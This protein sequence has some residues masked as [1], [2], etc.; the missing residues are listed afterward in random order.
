LTQGLVSH[1]EDRALASIPALLP[2]STKERQAVLETLNRMIAARGAR[3][4]DAQRL[5]IESKRSSMS[6]KIGRCSAEGFRQERMIAR[7]TSSLLG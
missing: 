1:D 2:R 7:H 3:S 4:Q 5:S 6:G